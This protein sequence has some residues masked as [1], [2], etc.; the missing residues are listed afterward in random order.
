MDIRLVVGRDSRSRLFLSNVFLVAVFTVLSMAVTQS[1]IYYTYS[2]LFDILLLG[3]F[4]VV[5]TFTGGLSFR[6]K[7]LGYL[8]ACLLYFIATTIFFTKDMVSSAVS[9]F[10]ILL[11]IAVL[12]NANMKR[13]DLRWISVIILL[14]VCYLIF[15]SKD[16]IARFEANTGEFMLNPNT[17]GFLLALF[18]GLLLAVSDKLTGHYKF[19][20]ELL[21]IVATTV[22]LLYYKS[23][24]AILMFSLFLFLK[25]LLPMKLKENYKFIVIFSVFIIIAGCVIPIIYTL[26]YE[27]GQGIDLTLMDKDF[28]TGREWIWSYLFEQV[29]KTTFG[30]IF[31]IGAH[32]ANVNAEALNT[33]N[34]YLS[35]YM[36][37]GAIG[38]VAFFGY[39]IYQIKKIYTSVKINRATIDITML[40]ISMLLTGYFETEILWHPML[41]FTGLIWA[42]P[43]CL[44][45]EN[46]I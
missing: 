17:S 4:L 9:M 32:G 36:R 10:W 39:Y 33:H 24:T 44:A 6:K 43:I 31:G 23:R 38:V 5:F 20:L 12:E 28:F 22:G 29:G 40:G 15:L 46:P 41:F 34:A 11:W 26:L 25:Y 16:S 27:N 35:I 21:L 37:F 30:W 45:K 7:D 13:K 1:Q 42:L 14:V 3:L 19:G 18:S 8:T 2:N